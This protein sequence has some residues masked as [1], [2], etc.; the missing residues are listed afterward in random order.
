MDV[1]HVLSKSRI[2]RGLQCQ[3]SLYF[4]L[5]HKE[6][7]A[8]VTPAIQFFFDEGNEVGETARKR[9]P[10]EVLNRQLEFPPFRGRFTAWDS[11]RA[12]RWL[13]VQCW[14]Y[15]PLVVDG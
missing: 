4:T 10:G 6:L 3:K 11:S 7:E 8:E 1:P 12:L 2:K 15:P 9:F 5:F 14:T 13:R